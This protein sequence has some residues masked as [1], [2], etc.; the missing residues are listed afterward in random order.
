[1]ALYYF[2]SCPQNIIFVIHHI[3][4][5]ALYLHNLFQYHTQCFLVHCILYSALIRRLTSLMPAF[6]SSVRRLFFLFFLDPSQYFQTLLFIY[7]LLFISMLSVFYFPTLSFIFI[8]PSLW[9]SPLSH[10]VSCIGHTNIFY[11]R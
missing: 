5:S 2:L 1:M 4:R 3:I 7:P 6:S 9:V 8:I 10:F 11:L